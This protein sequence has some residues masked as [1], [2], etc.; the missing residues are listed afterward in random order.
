MSVGAP[1]QQPQIG[2]M[3]GGAGKIPSLFPEFGG[4]SANIGPTPGHH[5]HQQQMHLPPPPHFISPPHGRGP[6]PPQ[7]STTQ[8]TYGSGGRRGGEPPPYSGLF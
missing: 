6:L 5:P 1:P 3:G 4:N 7:L 2:Q 8:P